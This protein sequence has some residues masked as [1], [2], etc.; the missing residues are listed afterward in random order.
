MTGRIRWI[1]TTEELE[2]VL[3]AVGRGPVAI[4]TEAD[5]FHH[6]PEKVCLL[7]LT[8]DARDVVVDPLAGADLRRLA[9]V[10]EDPAVRKLV[11][12][13]DYDVRILN[14]D[15]ELRPRGLFD[16][17][18]AA[19]LCGETMLGLS[20]LLGSALGVSLEKAHQRAD[21][22]RRPLPPEMLEY[23]AADT[24]HLADLAGVLSERLAALGRSAWAEE[25]CSRL[26]AVRWRATDACDPDA[27][28][29][30]KG[31]A[32]LDRRGLGV[33]REIWRWRDALARERDRPPF[34][35]LRDEALADLAR[36]RPSTREELAGVETVPEGLRRS[37]RAPSLL[38]AVRRGVE[39]PEGDLPELRQGSR[40]RPDPEVERRVTALRE[41]R[42]RVARD[43]G[44]DPPVV[45]SRAVLEGIAANLVRGLPPDD[46]PELRRWQW[47]LLAGALPS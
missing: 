16:T 37:S 36:R 21:W 30:V 15:F 19:K 38:E 24:R 44:L 46:V 13:G 25:E 6:Y 12:G 3:D 9:R 23:A 28:R 32:G 35:I 29:K 22:S 31:A 41:V 7:Q 17:M 27:F 5:S 40:L 4:D 42:D 11:H 2:T 8:F 39:L 20:A 18:I 14:R 43:L 26:E 33:L 45:A 10:L 1:S 34:K 47:Q